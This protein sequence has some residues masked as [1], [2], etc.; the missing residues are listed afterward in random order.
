MTGKETHLRK[1]NQQL[2]NEIA[3]LKKQLESLTVAIG[4]KGEDLAERAEGN[5]GGEAQ[6]SSKEES[7]EFIS[8]KYDDLVAFKKNATE[9]LQKIKSRLNAISDACDRLEK[10]I[11]AFE[12]YSYQFNVKIVGLPLLA[13]RETS[14]QTA[15]LCLQLFAKM[16]VKDISINDIDTAHRV[17]SRKPSDRPNAVICK[18]VRR[19]AKEK[20]MAARRTVRNID[21]EQL[22]FSPGIDVSHLYLYDHLTP[23]LQNLLFEAKKYKD[24]NNFKFCWAKNGF[25]YLRKSEASTIHKFCNLDQLNSFMLG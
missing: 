8:A 17:P 21:A 15:Y 12:M 24:A 4:N 23:R 25:I 22:G 3:D 6:S 9:E 13:E 5:H 2:R 19:L 11:D 20:V 1:E 18:F 7:V 14:E 10:S 16:G